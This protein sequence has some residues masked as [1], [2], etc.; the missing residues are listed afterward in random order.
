MT[1]FYNETLLSHSSQ[2]LRSWRARLYANSPKV[3]PSMLY[4]YRLN[5]GLCSAPQHRAHNTHIH[6]RTHVHTHTHTSWRARLYANSPKVTPSMLYQYRLNLGLCSA[7]QHRAHNTH[8]HTRT[9][10]HTHT[11]THTSWRARLYANSPKVTPS[12]LYQYRL[13]LGLCSAPQ[14]RARNTH[15]RTHTVTSAFVCQLPQ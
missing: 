14:H 6:T 12:M 11:H 8:I 4:Q 10:V 3:T 5:L 15:T 9:H 7:P 1:S 13:N 2:F